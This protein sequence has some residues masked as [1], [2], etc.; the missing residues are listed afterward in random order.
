M[1]GYGATFFDTPLGLCGLAWS[2]RGVKALQLP[3]ET[4]EATR[5]RLM[6]RA[7]APFERRPPAEIEE[8]VMRI[9][10]LL[11]GRAID[12]SDIAL[13]MDRVGAFEAQVY[14]TARFIPCGETR[15]YGQIA[16]LIGR[17]KNARLV[18]RV[19]SHAEHYGEYPC[20]RVVSAAGRLAPGWA[21]QAELLR[22]E[23]VPLKANG[24]VDLRKYGWDC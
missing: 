4:P 15:T 23:G 5:T 20:Q 7:G 12:L 19:L 18:G 13:D 24:C 6:R 1:D 10:K 8:I 17:D 3:E 22:A 21:Q 9:G 11:A 14:A 2:P 16:R